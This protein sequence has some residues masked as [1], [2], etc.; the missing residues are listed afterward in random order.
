MKGIA[1]FATGVA[2][3]SCFPQAVEAGAAGN[4]LYFILGGVFGL[5]PDT[6]DFKLGRFLYRHHM[7][8]RPDPL[9]PDP[10]MIADTIALAIGRAHELK[11]PFRIRLGAV[12]LGPDEWQRYEVDFDVVARHVTVRFG[13]AVDTSGRPIEG[14]SYRTLEASAS[15]PC[16][17]KLD[18]QARTTI[19]IFDGPVFSMDPTSDDRVMPVFIPWH[20]QWSHCLL[21]TL[22]SGLI[23]GLL[24]GPLAGVVACLAAAAH[25]L[26]DQFGHMGSNVFAPFRKGRCAGL[27]I[28]HSADAFPNFATVWLACMLIFWN[29]ARTTGGE[30]GFISLPKLLFYGAL[31]P[32]ALFRLALGRERDAGL[33]EE[34]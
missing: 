21:M 25:V 12:R 4:P 17:I 1:H 27:G 28:V 31:I 20:R 13:P 22:V 11:N 2:V 5:L 30:D 32:L 8:V 10:Q 33:L 34:A 6:L 24:A 15:L 14:R 3:A 19:D 7:E 9:Q 18:Y 29:L 23:V 16:A 26:L